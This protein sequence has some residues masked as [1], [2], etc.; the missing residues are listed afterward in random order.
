MTA[1]SFKILSQYL[2]AEIEENYTK[3]VRI[4]GLR[5]GPVTSQDSKQQC[6]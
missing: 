4:T 3:S 5:F 1:V 6:R 2:F